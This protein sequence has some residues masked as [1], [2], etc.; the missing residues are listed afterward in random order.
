M[1]KILMMVSALALCVGCGHKSSPSGVIEECWQRLS[2][3]KVR[4]AVELMDV[5]ES[6]VALYRQIYEEQCGELLEAGGMTDFE[7]LS[8]SQ[9]ETDATVEA[10]V[11]LRNGQNIGAT[12]KL[13]KRDKRWLITE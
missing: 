10:I 11:T 7:V 2:E 1:K 4:E 3:G 5:A 8:F 9:G 12:Y 13:I 6:E